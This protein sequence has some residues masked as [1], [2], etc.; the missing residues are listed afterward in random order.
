MNTVVAYRGARIEDASEIA[1]IHATSWRENYRGN[2]PDSFLDGPVFA[3]RL[4]LWTERLGSAATC[5]A[6]FVAELGAGTVGFAHVRPGEGAIAFLDDVY[7]V[8]ALKRQGIG[9]GLLAA[10][11]RF[12][13]EEYGGELYLWVP[14]SNRAAQRFFAA[15]GGERAGERTVEPPGSGEAI[16]EYRIGWPHPSVLRDGLA[17]PAR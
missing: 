8:G 1:T 9:T 3:D 6:T 5:S 10:V 15:R 17:G 13:D 16:R 4:S 12:V 11:G 7:V 2:Y 14:E